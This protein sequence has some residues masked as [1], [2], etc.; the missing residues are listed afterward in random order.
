MTTMGRFFPTV[1]FCLYVPVPLI[2]LWMHGAAA[3]WPRLKR[4]A[5][6]L[7][8]PVYC[9]LVVAA[10]W[11]HRYIAA[12]AWAWPDAARAGGLVLVAAAFGLLAATYRRIDSWTAMAGPQITA[13]SR[14]TLITGGVYGVI[15]HPRY[16][17][18][19][20]GAAGNFLATGYPLLLAAAAVTTMLTLI[21]VRV[22]DHE[23]ERAFG[24]TYRQ[25][26]SQVP[27]LVPRR[28][29]PST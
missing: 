22:E 11:S 18:L 9:G 29:G 1:I 17:V 26:R 20:I 3:L 28:P 5:Y 24:D 16:A 15:R 13:S 6:L 25:Y 10:A 4:R 14:R 27:A 2:M 8:V 7:H 21:L 19:V 12:G 23:L